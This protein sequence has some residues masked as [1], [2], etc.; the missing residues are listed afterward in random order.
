MLENKPSVQSPERH[1]SSVS[2]GGILAGK[3]DLS[4]IVKNVASDSRRGLTHLGPYTI[5]PRIKTPSYHP[6]PCF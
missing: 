2:L 3:V 1:G 5:F 4:A 6:E